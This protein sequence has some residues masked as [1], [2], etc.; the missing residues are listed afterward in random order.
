[1]AKVNANDRWVR[2]LRETESRFVEFEFFVSDKDLCVELILP[3][4]AFR[5]FCAINRVR[6]LGSNEDPSAIASH[7]GLL[8]RIK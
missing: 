1:M 6:F 8:R 5:E 3:T 7:C 2:V 4:P